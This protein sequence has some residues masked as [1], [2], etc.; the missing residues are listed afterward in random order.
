MGDSVVPASRLSRRV[1]EVK[2]SLGSYIFSVDTSL[3]L[4]IPISC[5]FRCRVGFT[6]VLPLLGGLA[7]WHHWGGRL[8]RRAAQA[9]APSCRFVCA[10]HSQSLM[11]N[12]KGVGFQG[13]SCAHVC[14]FFISI[15]Y[16]F[17]GL[18]FQIMSIWNIMVADASLVFKWSQKLRG[19]LPP[20]AWC[21]QCCQQ[22]VGWPFQ[23]S[24]DWNL[25]YYGACYL[26]NPTLVLGSKKRSWWHQM[27]PGT[28]VGVC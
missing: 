18:Q 10:W 21:A 23:R 11:L 4:A 3:W 7:S 2:A 24:I 14:P 27:A 15:F 28:T 5:T 8:A 6:L 13:A 17:S 19:I 22:L 20:W 12:G 25:Y 1:E 9:L 16:P 26:Q